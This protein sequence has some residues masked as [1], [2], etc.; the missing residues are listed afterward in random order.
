MCERDQL[1]GFQSFFK[2]FT[3]IS[4]EGYATLGWKIFVKKNPISGYACFLPLGGL[5]GKSE[6]ITI[7][8]LN[9]PPS[10]GV[11]TINR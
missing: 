5:D 8:H 3:Q 1:V 2:V 7:L 10:K 11:S 6:S 9:T 4:P